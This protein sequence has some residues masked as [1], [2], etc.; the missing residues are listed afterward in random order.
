MS[1]KKLKIKM[2]NWGPISD[3]SIELA[4]LS[5]FIGPNNSGKS[6][7]ARLIQCIFTSLLEMDTTLSGG[8]NHLTN[9]NKLKS[10]NRGMEVDF[11]S[12]VGD[13]RALFSRKFGES[14]ILILEKAF[15]SSIDKLARN[16]SEISIIDIRSGSYG[17]RFDVIKR[18]FSEV[19]LPKINLIAHH[20]QKG[21]SNFI[22]GNDHHFFI[23]ESSLNTNQR[24]LFF[25]MNRFYLIN[26]FTSLFYDHSFY[27]PAERHALM[28]LQSF[29][30]PLF[31]TDKSPKVS[32]LPLFFR[33]LYFNVLNSGL[34]N[35]EFS[36]LAEKMS[37]EIIEGRI[38]YDKITGN[39]LYQRNGLVIPLFLASTTVSQMSSLLMVLS[40]LVRKGELL[41]IEE[42]EAHLHPANQTI[43][44]KYLVKL[45]RAGVK[46]LI[47]THSDYLVDELGAF[48]LASELEEKK[49]R[50]IFKEP[51]AYLNPD[52][53]SAY[54]F[55]PDKAAKGFKTRKLKVDAENGIDLKEFVKVAMKV[56]DTY[57][58]VRNLKMKNRGC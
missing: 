2:H 9:E 25:D 44:A 52:E 40:G 43:L 12:Y 22:V 5:I 46:I 8:F 20:P 36:R 11:T 6:Y 26:H 32:E 16:N 41:I 15:L 56:H 31:Y 33:E 28:E 17:M 49:R 51:D 21:Q 30:A 23:D 48:L 57:V 13:M 24:N 29:L 45:I 18:E 4:P 55:V 39:I 50:K 19:N 42:P 53:V 58:E 7:A 54:A 47:T 38:V 3:S 10:L 27:F 1:E 37:D 35:G 34:K 14:F